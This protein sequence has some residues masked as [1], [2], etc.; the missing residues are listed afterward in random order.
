MCL[1]SYF[2]PGV[3]ADKRALRLGAEVN[4]EGHGCAIIVDGH[5]IVDKGMDFEGV[6]APF[7]TLRE[8]YPDSPAVF[9]S[10]T[11][12][13]G[14]YGLEGCQPYG[15]DQTVIFHNGTLPYG[16]WVKDY[17]SDTA[18]FADTT[19]P[20]CFSSLDD[21][22]TFGALEHWM[23]PVNKMVILTVNP[24]YRL[25]AYMV[26]QDQFI[27][28]DGAYYSNSDFLGK[29]VGWDEE[30]LVSHGAGQNVHL[31]RWRLTQPG[32]CSRCHTFHK[33]TEKHLVKASAYPAKPAWRDETA[34][35][36]K[37]HIPPAAG[38]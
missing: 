34:R 20:I 28:K 7:L 22:D 17:P 11:V 15:D 4:D 19:F 38:H 6:L 21:D 26:H 24:S 27:E 35:R 18:A 9:W 33:P 5:L 36:T 16:G 3:P 31:Y 32:Q 12:S 2:P 10:R 13:A 29:G 30:I 25:N 23:T 14:E 37:F 8:L 1:L